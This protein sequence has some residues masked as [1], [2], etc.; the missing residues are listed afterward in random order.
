MVDVCAKPETEQ[1]KIVESAKIRSIGL[2]T[3]D[4]TRETTSNKEWAKI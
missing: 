2:E 4:N 1:R 3:L